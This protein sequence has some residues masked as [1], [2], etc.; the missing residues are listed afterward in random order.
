MQ[1]HLFHK[2]KYIHRRQLL[3]QSVKKGIIVLMGNVESPMN[4]KANWYPFRQDSHFL[5]FFGLNIPGLAAVLD[6]ESGNE[7][8]FGNDISL[9]D[10]V[11]T[12]PLPS[13][14]DMAEETGIT[15]VMPLQEI[16]LLIKNAIA[17][18]RTVHFL[19]PYRTE[20]LL[21]L[22]TWLQLPFNE[23]QSKVSVDLIKAIVQQRSLKDADEANELHRAAM[24]SRQMHIAAMQYAKSG[25]KEYEL[26][27]V[28]K[29]MAYRNDATLS[30]NPIVTVHGETLHNVYSG[31]SLNNGDIV[32]CDAGATTEKSYAGD[33]TCTFPVSK[34]FTTQQKELYEIVLNAQQYAVS[35]L[36]P[37]IA[38]K[39]IHL[40]ACKKLTEGLIQIGAMKGN[41]DDAVAHHA[42]TLFFQCGLGHMIGLDVH[43]MED[44]GEEYVGYDDEIK[45]EAIF[46]LK[47]LRL[48]KRLQEGFALTVEP[49]LY[50]IPFLMQ[51]WQQE[52]KCSDFINYSILH[53]F[54][55]C[56]GIRIEETILITTDGSKLLG[57]SLPKTVQQVEAVRSNST[58]GPDFI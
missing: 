52:K 15:L 25:M 30:F 35:L 6:T 18:N 16:S 56:R 51:Q 8:I 3:M 28:V 29:E 45:K 48:G 46:G 23:I 20:N 10:I 36:K 26:S 47:F 1:L 44:L 54:S 55:D 12:G 57:A 49:G 4:Y 13:L 33:L 5:Y 32:L 34:S 43:D 9:D 50:F 11:W 42:H 17:A 58:N 7:I 24:I 2:E 21:K 19:P 39:E 41:A 27:A 37:G 22:S 31:N 38:F 14:K 40:Q 53:H